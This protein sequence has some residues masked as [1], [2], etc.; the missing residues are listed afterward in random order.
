MVCQVPA[1]DSAVVAR[2]ALKVAAD[3]VRLMTHVVS[4][5]T[6][7]VAIESAIAAEASN[8]DLVTKKIEIDEKIASSNDR[9]LEEI[10]MDKCMTGEEA[11]LWDSAHRSYR[12]DE[13]KLIKDSGK[14]YALILGQCTQ[15][16]LDALQDDAD[17]DDISMK[18]DHDEL[19]K[20]IEKCVLKQTSSKYPYLTLIEEV[21]GL[22]NYVQGEQTPIVYYKGVSNRVSICEKAGMVF[23]VPYL[24][25]LEAEILHPGQKYDVLLADEQ[26][27]IRTI[28]Q[29]KFLGTLL[30]ERS[31]KKHDQLKDDCRNRYSSGDKNN[32]F[33]KT[34]GEAM[35]RMQDF[36]RIVIPEKTAVA[37]GTAFAGKGGKTSKKLGRMPPDEW[38]ALSKEEQKKELARRAAES[39]EAAAAAESG[40]KSTSKSKAKDNDDDDDAKSVASLTKELKQTQHKLK[41]TQNCLVAV[42][43]VKEDLTDEEGS[44]ILLA[45]LRLQ[46]A[47][48]HKLG[49]NVLLNRSQGITH[50]RRT[51][52]QVPRC[53]DLLQG[54]TDSKNCIG[55][56]TTGRSNVNGRRRRGEGAFKAMEKGEDYVGPWSLPLKVTKEHPKGMPWESDE[57]KKKSKVPMIAKLAFVI[58][59]SM[60]DERRG[61]G[62]QSPTRTQGVEE[63][64]CDLGTH[65]VHSTG[66]KLRGSRHSKD[67]IPTNGA[68]SFIGT[69]ESDLHTKYKLARLP[70]AE[71]PREDAEMSL[72]QA[73]MYLSIRD[74]EEKRIVHRSSPRGLRPSSRNLL[75]RGSEYQE[76]CHSN[77]AYHCTTGVLLTSQKGVKKESIK[78][79]FRKVFT[80]EQNRN[81][82]QSKY[83]KKTGLAR[84]TDPQADDIIVAAATLGID[85]ELALSQD[86]IKA[87][88]EDREFEARAITFG[89]ASLGDFEAIDPSEEQSVTSLNTRRSTATSR[90]IAEMSNAN[91]LY[92]ICT[93]NSDSEND[94]DEDNTVDNETALQG[95]MLFEN[96]E[97]LKGQKEN[98]ATPKDKE[99][100]ERK[101]EEADLVKKMTRAQM[102]EV[103][104]G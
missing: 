68:H 3:T 2:H 39:A 57:Q 73:L 100:S 42:C 70:D 91:T 64:T 78:K 16:L 71:G 48:P 81:V 40:K 29:D 22:L 72:H 92:S 51:R 102:E 52:S 59:V 1:Y 35:Q 95:T 41:A 28:V 33:P 21:R 79:F 85:T 76:N 44:N 38:F 34:P 31:D 24:L 4:L 62:E 50:K 14:V 56:R 36:R 103:G 83:D 77:Q 84:V 90:S 86:Q 13:Q 82:T 80:A 19:Y 5:Q 47:S 27:K 26:G 37:Q 55:E 54:S 69:D 65:G 45:E 43:E 11:K 9:L 93:D 10:D 12:E 67:K 94:S 98:Q 6:H 88:K 104:I 60:K 97:V 74:G 53:R 61:E 96:L 25:D 63:V 46:Q 15:T 99:A 23:H 17:W 8:L 20:L 87:R 7:L 18:C 32:A 75:K 30:L 49:S 101:K 58:H 66:T 89:A